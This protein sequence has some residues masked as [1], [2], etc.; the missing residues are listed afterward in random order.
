[1]TTVPAPMSFIKDVSTIASASLTVSIRDRTIIL[2]VGLFLAMVLVSAYLG[3]SAT[4]TLDQIF[5]KAALVLQAQGKAV[6]A[7]PAL[8]VPPLAS[9]RNMTTYVALLGV[10]AM[11]VVGTQLIAMD[12]VSGTLPLILSRPITPWRYAI[13]KLVALAGAVCILMSVAAIA[14]IVTLLMLPGQTITAD[15]WQGLFAF[16]ALSSV[17]LLIF[18]LIAVLAAILCRSEAMALLIPVTIWLALTFVL[19]QLTSNINPM[20][21]MNP[22]SA[23]VPRPGGL[24]FTVASTA[25][26][27]FSL[28]ES[29]RTLAA[30]SL[31]FLPADQT[32]LNLAASTLFL[33]GAA[34]AL[35]SAVLTVIGGF[36]A[37]RSDYN[38]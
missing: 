10:I 32:G 3:W 5:G 9:L 26:G 35:I 38:D 14:N 20:A 23:M 25:L 13:G 15:I 16:Y 27:P 30:A 7:N 18:G 4:H 33:V 29:Y 11:I 21:A 24:F 37:S 34:I 36:D 6:P 1:M 28:T 12:R 19:P 2:L 8:D 22:I 31:G 17:Y